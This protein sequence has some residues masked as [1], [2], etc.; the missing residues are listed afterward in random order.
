ML[1]LASI[2]AGTC[3]CV[4]SSNGCLM[5]VARD[6]HG[7]LMELLAEAIKYHDKG[8]LNIFRRGG[9]LHGRLEPCGNGSPTVADDDF[10][11]VLWKANCLD[12]NRKVSLTLARCVCG[13]Y[14]CLQVL[15]KLK[16]DQHEE[17]LLRV[18]EADVALGRMS[19][20]YEPGDIDLADA[21]VASRFSVEQGMSCIM[22]SA[23]RIAV[24]CSRY[25]IRRF[26]K[27]KA[28]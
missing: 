20:L 11:P 17:E 24:V 10:D 4:G 16:D 15:S 27:S 28:H 8:C 25:K 22:L 21:A 2:A 18:S 23:E 5:Q 12:R 1:G 6:V 14:V 26:S 13:Q 19:G 9:T 3:S 7:P